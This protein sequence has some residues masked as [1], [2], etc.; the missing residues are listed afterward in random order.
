MAW[1]HNQMRHWPFVEGTTGH[2]WNPTTKAS[3]TELWCFIWS[4]PEQVIAQTMKTPVI[5][6]AIAPLW[7]PCNDIIT[8]AF[9]LYSRNIHISPIPAQYGMSV[10]SIFEK[11]VHV[12]EFYFRSSGS[13]PKSI[14]KRTSQCHLPSFNTPQS[15]NVSGG[16]ILFLYSCNQNVLF[17][18]C[19]MY[20]NVTFA[21]MTNFVSYEN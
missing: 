3:D 1:W 19:T 13:A 9:G 15:D 8:A 17:G 2:R 14:Q 5:W 18:T 7:R 11:N 10:E 12:I 6:D 20:S 16:L 4:A 21:D